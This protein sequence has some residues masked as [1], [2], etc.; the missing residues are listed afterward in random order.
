MDVD[1]KEL[2]ELEKLAKKAV[3]SEEGWEE[4]HIDRV[5]LVNEDKETFVKA[6]Y[7]RINGKKVKVRAHLRRR[8][9][10]K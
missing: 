7:R 3:E 10:R 9:K 2:E 1:E 5:I 8:P 4:A 6:H